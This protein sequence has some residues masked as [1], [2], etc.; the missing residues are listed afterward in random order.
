MSDRKI[1][2]GATILPLD[3]RRTIRQGSVLIDDGIIAAIGGVTDTH[4]A[5]IT[6]TTSVLI[7]G[8]VQAHLHLTEALLDRDFVASPDPWFY[9]HAQIASWIDD[10]APEDLEI[11][12]MAGLVRGIVAGASTFADA[13]VGAS[14]RSAID[15]AVS[16][17]ARLVATV[18]ARYTDPAPD[19]AVLSS[20][21]EA[22]GVTDRIS[23]AV[24]AGDAERTGIARLGSAARAAEDHQIPL[25]VQAGTMPGDRMALVRLE[26]AHALG[27]RLVI[28]HGCGDALTASDAPA[29]LAEAGAS[30][31]LTPAHDLLIG[32][33][34]PPLE[35]LL[36]AGV[37]LG[38][39]SD[40]ATT[41]CGL[42]PFCDARL[43]YGMLDGRVDQPATTALEI[44]ARGGAKALGLRAGSVE[45]SNW[46]DLALVDIPTDGA[47]SHEQIAA[48]ILREGGAELTR[49]VWIHGQVVATDGR[50]VA[51]GLPTEEDE[52]AVRRRQ[53]LHARSHRRSPSYTAARIRASLR[54]MNPHD[55]WFAGRLPYLS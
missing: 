18:D 9:R 39:G 2:R 51:E 11:A 40:S 8:L 45:V 43:L 55:G 19:L 47:E 30:I 20:V 1:I 31:V 24:W 4:G 53:R 16:V 37:T 6:E 13:G 29:V 48:Q 35:A 26:Q 32:A 42:D 34:P 12:A 33:P 54:R 50:V 15:A 23:L 3:G 41:R 46:A 38:L 28:C 10:T 22:Q 36:E 52:D 21:I 44:A 27:K 7:P 14:A 25:L 5:L 17:G 49:T